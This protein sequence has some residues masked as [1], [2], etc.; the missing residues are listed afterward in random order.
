M[1]KFASYMNAYVSWS[2]KQ[3]T[4]VHLK[5][6]IC[7]VYTK[8]A[9]ADKQQSIT[10]SKDDLHHQTGSMKPSLKEFWNFLP[11]MGTIIVQNS[12]DG[13]DSEKWFFNG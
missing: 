7:L 12:N 6:M 10:W 5:Q 11:H 4:L 1:I 3:W 8:Q 9:L 13:L 2:K